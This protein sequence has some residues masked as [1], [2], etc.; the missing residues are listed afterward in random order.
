MIAYA[1][2]CKVDQ[3]NRPIAGLI[4]F[5]PKLLKDDQKEIDEVVSQI[6]LKNIY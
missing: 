2:Y 5:C 6:A 1:S 3:H 4:T